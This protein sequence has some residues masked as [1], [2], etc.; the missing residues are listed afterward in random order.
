MLTR[1]AFVA[2]S[3]LSGVGLWSSSVSAGQTSPSGYA[4]AGPTTY[5]AVTIASYG[6]ES[7]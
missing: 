2:G 4:I 1:H 5:R 7:V 6:A 3:A